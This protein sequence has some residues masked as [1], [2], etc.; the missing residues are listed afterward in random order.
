MVT[1]PKSKQPLLRRMSSFVRKPK[2][3]REEELDEAEEEKPKR[4]NL[5]RRLSSLRVFASKDKV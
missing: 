2:E 3:N 4:S 1:E 5:I